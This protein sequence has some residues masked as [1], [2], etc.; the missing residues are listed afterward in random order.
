VSDLDAQADINY[1]TFRDIEADPK[2]LKKVPLRVA[3]RAPDGSVVMQ[4]VMKDVPLPVDLRP[5][6]R[7][8]RPIVKEMEL[9]STDVQRAANPGLQA[10]RVLLGRPD[11]VKASVAEADLGYLKSV[12]RGATSATTRNASQGLAARA[13]AALAKQIRDVVAAV[14]DPRARLALESGRKLTAA[15]YYAQRLLT[16]LEGRTPEFGESV[17]AYKKLTRADDQAITLLRRVAKREPDVAPLIGRAVLG[18]IFAKGLETGELG[19]T[20]GMFRDWQNLGPATKRV[21]FKPA[22]IADLDRFFL[23]LKKLDENVNP[24]GTGHAVGMIEQL[25]PLFRVGEGALLIYNW[26]TFTEIQLS[27]YAVAKLLHTPR[28]VRALTR[29]LELSLRKP[30]S[31]LAATG[32]VAEIQRAAGAAGVPAVPVKV[33]PPAAPVPLPLAADEGEPDR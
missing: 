22:L 20:A 28:G 27:A 33:T 9:R 14:G 23:L 7:A 11:F 17:G 25:K 16:K 31:T 4:T 2:N 29:G 32:A 5:I 12:T 8:L 24:S 1:R 15:K 30:A 19:R 26:A 13:Q 6:K 21:L 10:M 3:M 18:E